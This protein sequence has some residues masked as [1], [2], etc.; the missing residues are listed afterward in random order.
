MKRSS[1]RRVPRWPV[2]GGTPDARRPPEIDD[3]DPAHPELPPIRFTAWLTC[4]QPIEEPN[5][6]S[7]LVVVWF[8][9]ECSGEPLDKVVN[10]AIRALPWEQLAQ[11]FEGW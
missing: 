4:Y 7:E 3:S 8:R 6:G 2:S 5:A 9:G 10:D 11:D 1:S